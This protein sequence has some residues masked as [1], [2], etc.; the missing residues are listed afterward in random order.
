M[1]CEIDTHFSF[2]VVECCAIFEGSVTGGEKLQR[3]VAG[4]CLTWKTLLNFK[5]A[6]EI[7]ALFIYYTDL[8]N[9]MIKIKKPIWKLITFSDHS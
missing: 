5:C 7:N 3:L 4:N 8:L 2:Q 6:R 9:L 1:T